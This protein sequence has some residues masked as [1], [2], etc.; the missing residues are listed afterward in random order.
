[1][2]LKINHIYDNNI[3]IPKEGG[4]DQADK[5][6]IDEQNALMTNLQ[7]E[8]R[9]LHHQLKKKDDAVN[10][11]K[12][13]VEKKNKEEEEEDHFGNVSSIDAK[14]EYDEILNS[15]ND[16]FESGDHRQEEQK[17]VEMLSNQESID[18]KDPAIQHLISFS[19]L[20]SPKDINNILS[21]NNEL[22]L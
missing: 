8:V 18:L 10:Q 5:K 3:L 20:L 1:M 13:F 15:I 9:K 21:S 16:I 11:L 12:W 22:V 6:G 14:L 17:I 4:G 19:C 7:E 2:Q